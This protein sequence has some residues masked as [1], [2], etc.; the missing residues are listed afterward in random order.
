[1][2]VDYVSINRQTL[3]CRALVDFFALRPSE[4]A[5]ESCVFMNP[6]LS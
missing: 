2:E 5:I 1:M 6:W 3:R 4:I